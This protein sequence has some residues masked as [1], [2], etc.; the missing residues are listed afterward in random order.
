M[1]A[2]ITNAVITSPIAGVAIFNCCSFL[3][4]LGLPK[5]A[6]RVRSP[7]GRSVFT[8]CNFREHKIHTSVL[9]L[10]CNSRFFCSRDST[11]LGTL[12]QPHAN[13]SGATTTQSPLEAARRLGTVRGR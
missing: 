7:G 2:A 4:F 5:P 12:V 10:A 13:D 3:F 6:F 8:F 9:I 1:A 11:N